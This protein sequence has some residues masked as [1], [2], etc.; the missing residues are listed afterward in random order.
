MMFMN[1][2]P[3]C[4]CYWSHDA[5]SL[6]NT[7]RIF[8][9]WWMT[10]VK[11]PDRKYMLKGK[12]FVWPRGISYKST[13]TNR[14]ITFVNGLFPISAL[15]VLFYSSQT[16]KQKMV[17]QSIRI[18]ALFFLYIVQH[19]LSSNWKAFFV[20]SQHSTCVTMTQW[21]KTMASKFD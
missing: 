5:Y 1:R 3:P 17:C 4:T 14:N 12:Y 7:I 16:Y 6:G 11:D 10:S 21:D 15:I 20:Y 13:F 2:S 18:F 8:L 19:T 9:R